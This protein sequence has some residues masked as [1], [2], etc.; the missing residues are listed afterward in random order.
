[1]IPSAVALATTI[2]AEFDEDVVHTSAWDKTPRNPFV[3]GGVK[4]EADKAFAK[5]V[6][7]G[8][9]FDR[10]TFDAWTVGELS[11]ILRWAQKKG[12]DIAAF[13]HWVE[14][15]QHSIG[16]MNGL[17]GSN[18]IGGHQ[19]LDAAGHPVKGGSEYYR[20]FAMTYPIHDA[21]WHHPT[22][23]GAEIEKMLH[24]PEIVAW[25]VKSGLKL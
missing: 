4:D 7:D 9:T 5:A 22:A 19:V 2:K 15:W 8:I 1:M 12:G 25:A 11:Y 18:L 10:A 14:A 23:P 24:G 16:L 13:F 17:A 21:F 20:H 3:A 6:Y